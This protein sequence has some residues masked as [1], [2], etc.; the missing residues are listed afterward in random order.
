MGLGVK[1]QA[2]LNEPNAL[3]NQISCHRAFCIIWLIPDKNDAV[4]N[5][6][7]IPLRKLG[8]ADAHISAL[9]CG[10]HH[11]G[12]FENVDD[13]IRMVQE[14]VD[15][16]ITFFDN[17]W[18]YWN[19]KSENILGRALQGRRDKVFVMTKVCTH[20]R[21]ARLAMEMLEASLRRL[22]TDHLDLW[23]IHGV[24]CQ[25]IEF[26]GISLYP[27]YSANVFRMCPGRAGKCSHFLRGYKPRFGSLLA[28]RGS[29]GSRKEGSFGFGFRPQRRPKQP[30]IRGGGDMAYN[31][32]CRQCS[33]PRS[34]WRRP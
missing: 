10:G 22:R 20:G 27:G 6:A 19:G 14:A 34:C 8:C 12:D 3:C 31:V 17:C 18:E 7:A 5:P 24:V 26:H 2:G 21:S 30:S 9:G 25:C 28:H 13:A 4:E 11:L 16:G 23:Q 32:T 1:H 29:A 15:G 33:V